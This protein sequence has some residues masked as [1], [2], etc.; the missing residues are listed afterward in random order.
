[1]GI[2]S[3]KRKRDKR[4]RRFNLKEDQ[5]VRE[6]KGIAWICECMVSQG[7]K[8]MFFG[9]TINKVNVFHD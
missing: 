9:K 2:K 4:G 6:S 1:M 3:F 5:D 7:G 8:I